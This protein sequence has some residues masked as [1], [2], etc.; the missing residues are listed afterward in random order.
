MSL[1]NEDITPNLKNDLSAGNLK[2]ISRTT[3]FGDV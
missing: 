3:C 1:G 2:L